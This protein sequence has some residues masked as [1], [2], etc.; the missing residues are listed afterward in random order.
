MSRASLLRPLALALLLALD[1]RT[2]AAAPAAPASASTPADLVGTWESEGSSRGGLG[3]I[4]RPVAD[5]TLFV[6]LGA[7]VDGSWTLKNGVLTV[8]IK[9]EKGP[10]QSANARVE[11]DVLV[12]SAEGKE[13]RFTRL[14]AAEAGAPPIVGCWRGPAMQVEGQGAGPAPVVE[15]AKSGAAK[16]RVAFRTDKGSWSVSGGRLTLVSPPLPDRTS[17]FQVKGTQLVLLPSGKQQQSTYRR[18]PAGACRLP[19]LEAAAAPLGPLK[20]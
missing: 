3:V 9:G 6:T 15:Y 11:G 8:S 17:P 20:P 4:L 19:F 2:A 7:V 14:G 13:I 10:P 5:G 1:A 16:I 12:Q 18:V